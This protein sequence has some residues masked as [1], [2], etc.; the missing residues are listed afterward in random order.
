MCI[1]AQRDIEVPGETEIGQLDVSTTVQEKVLWLEIS[2]QN[3][4]CMAVVDGLKQ[5]IQVALDYIRC[6]EGFFAVE[7]LFEVHVEI[8]KHQIDETTGD[9]DIEQLNNG[10]MLHVFQQGNLSHRC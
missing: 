3:A 6:D 4:I 8:L 1:S 9:D 7:K 5:L 10:V 2:M